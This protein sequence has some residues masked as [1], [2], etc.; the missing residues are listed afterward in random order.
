[1]WNDSVKIPN[2]Y[3]ETTDSDGFTTSVPIFIGGIPANFKSTTRA[4]ETLADQKGYTADI[5][6]EIMACNYEEQDTL[7]DEKNGRT[8]EIKR[9]HSAE[10]KETINLTCQR[11]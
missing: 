5:I 8:Y 1:M 9:T 11:R 4:D 10:G 7:I 2:G 3:T 6:I